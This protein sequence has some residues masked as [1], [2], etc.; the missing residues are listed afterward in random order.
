MNIS[1]K[2]LKNNICS[3]LFDTWDDPIAGSPLFVGI[4]LNELGSGH[5]DTINLQHPR[6]VR[7]FIMYA[8]DHGWTGAQRI[9]FPDGL[10][11]IQRLGY[12]VSLLKK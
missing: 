6:L 9:T 10:E 3:F 8:L 12:D 11:V 7:Q 2:E 5:L 4:S 1:P